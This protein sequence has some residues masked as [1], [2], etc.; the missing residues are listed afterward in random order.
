MRGNV[1]AAAAAFSLAA[2]SFA[3]LA[4][5]VHA[6][7]G[8]QSHGEWPLSIVQRQAVVPVK[9]NGAPARLFI[10]TG[11]FFSTL[12]PASAARLKLRGHDS[13]ITPTG[14]GG[15]AR[16]QLVVADDFSVGGG[17]YHHAEFLVVEH[18]V[19]ADGLIGQNMLGNVDVEYDF[20]NGMMR[21][22]T[23]QGCRG[24]ASLA[25][26]AHDTPVRVIPFEPAMGP[27]NQIHGTALINGGKVHVT[28]DTGAAYSALTIGAARRLGIRLDAPGVRPSGS[29]S[30]I[31]QRLINVYSV[32]IASF[33]IGGE[34]IKDTRIQVLDGDL[35]GSADM[36]L[37]AD[38]FL[39]HRIY[40]AESQHRLYFTYNGGPVFDA[41]NSATEADTTVAPS[42][43]PGAVPEAAPTDA[44]GFVHRAEAYMA[45]GEADKAIA[46]Y[47]S[48]I[49]ASPAD[50]ALYTD[51]GLAYLRNRRP[52]LALTD[53]D[54]AIAMYPAA[55]RALLA[56]GELR[57]LAKDLDGAKT[58]FAAALKLDPGAS[59]LIGDL[60]GRAGDYADAA[61]AFDTALAGKPQTEDEAPLFLGRC[62]ARALGGIDLDKAIADCN[63]AMR[64]RPG[65][66]I[67]LQL[68]GLAYLRQGKLDAAVA[69]FQAALRQEPK[70]PLALFAL[71][72]AELRKGETDKGNADIA[73][74][75]A[76]DPKL[77]QMLKAMG[78]T[79]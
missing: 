34:E 8:L 5:T 55:R 19:G 6:A 59:G 38:F 22:F 4:G 17:D 26:W 25:Y 1:A 66:P 36:L 67:Y 48:A 71:G 35:G 43:A 58:D 39:S 70:D 61:A 40:V 62:R 21:L 57:L 46:D 68:R 29:M 75:T 69:D 20:A 28:F 63:T 77:A 44:A 56:R 16:T 13:G 65:A 53:F 45:R 51:R 9:I 42:V 15:S 3:A 23:P 11:S 73:T 14:V 27:D 78:L 7:C 64:L 31:G 2:L 76:L 54:K 12:G 37:G 79:S 30:G 72:A 18:G 50:A 47:T 52:M 24:D 33:S 60:Y 32:P 41:G 49:A 10:D 74:A